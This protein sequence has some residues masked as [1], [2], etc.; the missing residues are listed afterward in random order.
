[1]TA[2]DKAI[3]IHLIL[4]APTFFIPLL[5]YIQTRINFITV[6]LE[7]NFLSNA[8][9]F[10]YH[11][12]F[13]QTLRK[14]FLTHSFPNRFLGII[15]ILSHCYLV[16]KSTNLLLIAGIVEGMNAKRK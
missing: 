12:R 13:T 7:S 2:C 16:M 3:D 11:Y 9:I 1:M 14:V 15:S 8:F 4:I 5:N 10:P 6:L